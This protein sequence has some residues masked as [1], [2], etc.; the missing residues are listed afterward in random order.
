[1]PCS[2]CKHAL[3]LGPFYRSTPLANTHQHCAHGP[4]GDGREVSTL[5]VRKDQACRFNPSR[6]EAKATYYESG[7]GMTSVPGGYFISSGT[8]DDWN[9]P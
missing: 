9:A 7:G 1:M 6:Y 5:A 4:H 8:P 2:D 3:P